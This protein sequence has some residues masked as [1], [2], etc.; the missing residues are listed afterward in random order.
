MRASYGGV[1][2]RGARDA[3]HTRCRLAA[4]M[5]GVTGSGLATSPATE[6]PTPPA[7]SMPALT[8][9]VPRSLRLPSPTPH[10]RY[11]STR[12]LCPRSRTLRLSSP[13]RVVRASTT[14]W[15]SRRGRDLPTGRVGGGF[16]GLVC[17]EG[18]GHHP[19]RIPGGPTSA[20]RD[21]RDRSIG[22]LSSTP[23]LLSQETRKG[24]RAS[25]TH[26]PS[27][28]ATAIAPSCQDRR[29]DFGSP[30]IP[31]RNRVRVHI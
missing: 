30:A 19:A 22:S 11:Q 21:S 24:N 16:H 2:S 8:V 5:I 14:A 29:Q 7:R 6:R 28:S 10:T 4:T 12:F 17:C 25:P 15:T 1:E 26:S 27:E 20:D 31:T 23:D 18:P 3:T 13:M 9:R